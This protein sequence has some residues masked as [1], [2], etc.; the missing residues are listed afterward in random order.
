MGPE[1]GRKQLQPTC[2]V[3]VTNRLEAEALA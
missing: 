1:M 3:E 2:S